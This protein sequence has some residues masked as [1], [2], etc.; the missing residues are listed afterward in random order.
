MSRPATRIPAFDEL[1][2]Q[3]EAL[4]EGVTGEILEPGV[5][6]TMA[7]PGGRHRFAGWRARR[8]LQ[9]SDL[10]EGGSGW[11]FEVE[12]EIKLPDGLLAVPDLSGWR[13][14]EE[15]PFVDANPIEVLPDFCCEVL[16]PTTARDDRR[17][18]LPLFA[19]SGVGW[20]WIVDPDLCTVEVYQTVET[21]AAL[22]LV[23][24]DDDVLIL[25]PFED[26]IDV[27]RFWKAR[28]AATR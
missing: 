6:R 15:P 22:V 25:P 28:A 21:L 11:W 10:A 12:A 20:T 2:R 8:A 16:S 14:T 9:G 5:V 13:V 7:R 4:P 23:A 24:K 1:Y 26:E 17:L 18:K 19:R 3:I 27:G